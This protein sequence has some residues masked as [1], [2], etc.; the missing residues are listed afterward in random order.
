[1]WKHQSEMSGND[2]SQAGRGPRR[3]GA[4]AALDFGVE[5]GEEEFLGTATSW[6]PEGVFRMQTH[7]ADGRVD[8]GGCTSDTSCQVSGPNWSQLPGVVVESSSTL[9]VRVQLWSLVVS[10]SLSRVGALG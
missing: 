2:Q 8:S 7:E 5:E 6:N 4:A 9:V 1:M 10:F 3:G